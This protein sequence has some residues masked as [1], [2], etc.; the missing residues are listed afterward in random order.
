MQPFT[1]I[2]NDILE[3]MQSMTEAE[4][5]LTALLV[6]VT[7]G[8]H[9]REARLTWSAIQTAC[10]FSSRSTVARAIDLVND[11]GF[12]SSERRSMWVVNSTDSVLNET[13][14]STE[15]VPNEDENSTVSVLDYST[16]SVLN[17]TL[18]STVSVPSSIY[19]EKELKE[20]RERKGAGATKPT[21]PVWELPQNLNTPEFEAAWIAWFK[22]LI[23]KN[24]YLTQ[25]S[26]EVLLTQL[27]AI[28]PERA[29][30][31]ILHSI[32]RRWLN[33]YEPELAQNGNGAN[34][35]LQTRD[36]IIAEAVASAGGW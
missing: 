19:K 15:C 14:N 34:G 30:A 13:L 36:E 24:S 8:Y 2:P 22:H 26:G 21:H 7:Y 17:E 35:R 6:R 10:N 11:R 29:T 20:K 5:K 9:K 27:S 1:K 12:F 32:N 23:E 16:D 4:S 28:G 33:V 25:T 3:A 31:A 18:N